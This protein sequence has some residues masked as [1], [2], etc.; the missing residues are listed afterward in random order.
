MRKDALV[1][2]RRLRRALTPSKRITKLIEGIL[3]SDVGSLTALATMATYRYEIE[4]LDALAFTCYWVAAKRGDVAA[5]Y[6]LGSAL[7]EGA[8]HSR[9][10]V[11][12]IAWLRRAR[13]HGSVEALDYLGYCYR[14]GIGVRRNEKKGFTLSLE[15]SA[16][17]AAAKY[18]VA[19]CYLRGIGIRKDVVVGRRL[20]R[21]AAR[22]GDSEALAYVTKYLR[23]GSSAR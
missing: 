21:A 14:H 6:N 3:A 19:V 5:Q 9:D 1:K 8:G 22:A 15:A 2:R 4:T 23:S 17:V 18:A 20:M 12:G 11:A 10:V 13:R 16:T 7:I